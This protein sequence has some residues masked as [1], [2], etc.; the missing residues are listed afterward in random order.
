MSMTLNYVL[1]DASLSD[2][3]VVGVAIDSRDVVASGLFIALPGLTCHGIDF[4][5]AVVEKGPLAILI[6]AADPRYDDELRRYMQATPIQ[7]IAMEGL[8]EQA[9]EI[10]ARFYQYP[11]QSM[12]LVGVTGTDGKTS[13]SQFIAA[14]L[15]ADGARAGVIGTI[16]NGLYG[17][18]APAT[19]T[20]PDV[21]SL[22]RTFAALRQQQA[23]AVVMEVSSH[24]LDQ[25]RVAGAAFDVAVL[26]NLGRDHLDYH[27]TIAHYQASKARLF[28]R[29]E[30]RVI[31][32]NADDA[33]GQQLAQAAADKRVIRYSVD[34]SIDADVSLLKQVLS[35][36]GMALEVA[37]PLGH[38]A[39][40]V[41]IVGE[42]N[43]VN[44][45]T[46]IATLVALDM[47]LEM[48]RQ[49]VSALL[50]VAGRMEL[51]TTAS[52]VRVVVDYAHTSQAL[53]AAL[54]ACRAHC[55]G[56]LTCV[57]GCGG[58]RDVGK[59][60]LMAKEA[61]QFADRVVVTDD[62][63]RTES[64][65]Q[66]VADICKGFSQPTVAEIERDRATAIRHAVASAHAG[67]WVLVAGKGHEDYQVIGTQRID[68]SDR[69]VVKE[70]ANG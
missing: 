53:G 37:T 44:L 27:G 55:Q 35:E 3:R 2:E 19:H 29:E 22:H 40:E 12:T 51:F 39:V 49:R 7:L 16:G 62:N 34:A 57:F 6:D 63:P 45:L 56:T 42:F 65:D 8:R 61:E 52:D 26:T 70:L 20:T 28:Q 1:N 17:E 32:V 60:A 69:A 68:Y 11:S 43:A 64:G 23:E 67:D 41:P 4:L 48:I 30:V 36:H 14:C 38:F 5:N 10:A 47:P 33:F 9:G 50:P 31:V 21:I 18:L 54:Q 25:A 66:I 46:V 59:R 24:A 15:D 13:V 58:D